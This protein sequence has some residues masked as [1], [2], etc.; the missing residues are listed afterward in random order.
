M[1]Q[2][3]GSN[4]RLLG[5][6]LGETIVHQDGH[7][8]FE[9]EEEVRAMAK[10]WRQGDSTASQRLEEIMPRI[11]GDL[12]L[13]D[14]TIKAF[15][16]YFQLVNL[17][18]ERQRVQVL[19]KR[20]E[21]AFSSGTS[22]DETII[23]GI[24]TLKL[25]GFSGEQVQSFL[26]SML[27]MLVFTAHP[28][29]SKRR[30]IRQI[31]SQVSQLLSDVGSR[32]LHLHERDGKVGL[33]R[34][35]IELLWQSS[36][37][38]ERRPTVM[39]EVRNTGLY[40]FENTLFELVPRIYEQI[41]HALKQNFPD[42]EFKVPTF[43]KYGTWIG[44]DRD[45][46]PFVT[47]AVTE[48]VLRAQKKQVLTLYL[49]DVD[50]LYQLLSCST[51]RT[52]FS[53]P[54][55]DSLD[56]DRT[57]ADE[58][59]FNVLDRFGQEPYRQKLVLMFRRLRAT[60]DANE[61]P[62]SD[63][64]NNPR[65]YR[66]A[67]EFRN[68]LVAIKESLL[69]NKGQFLARGRLERL[70]RAVDVFGFHLASMDIRQHAR[71][72]RTALAKVL[73][74]AGVAED[75]LA[76]EEPKRI[77]ALTDFMTN[78]QSDS[79]K[80]SIAKLLQLDSFDE[81]SAS[82]EDQET[83]KLV[84]LFE[85]IH[86]A[87]QQV[88][89]HT[90]DTYII[91]MTEGV[92]NM[93][94]I[95]VLARDAG[96]LGKLNIVPLFETVG[97]LLAAPAIMTE[98]FNHP[99]YAEH[100]ELRQRKQQIMI[101]YSDSNKD[102]GFMRANWMLFTAQRQMAKAC[103]DQNVMLTL[104]HGRGGSLGRGGG[105]TNRA[106]LAQPP[107]SVRGRIRITEQGEVVSS[108]YS[109]PA[110]ASRHLE[111]VLHAMIC[112]TGKRPEIE[113]TEKWSNIMDSLS[114]TAYQKYRSLVEHDDF[115]EYFQTATPIDQIDQLNIGSRPSHRRTTKSLDD[116]RAIP[117]VFAWTQSRANVPSWYGIGTAFSSW[118][119]D[120]QSATDEL[121]DKTQRL[122]LLQTMY[123]QWPFFRTM[124]SNVHLGMGRAD[125]EIA[126]MYAKLAK[127]AV[128]DVI[129]TDIKT[130]FELSREMLLQITKTWGILATEPWLQH[131]I[132][133]R[134][135]Y[136]D[137]LNYIQVALLKE[138]RKNPAHSDLKQLQNAIMLSINGIAAGLQN[139]G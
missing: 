121:T 107:E 9:L 40:F 10:A 112:S 56:Q 91:S 74:A 128:A 60:R 94:E 15:L 135:P 19:R 71:H 109:E 59:E 116:L 37:T 90:I 58:S 122:A 57:L 105:P 78:H 36:E 132:K 117:W 97:D 79:S 99:L 8:A 84:S 30:T 1:K 104:F 88:G 139:V 130:E 87:Q 62:W 33:L 101:G 63:Q 14:S 80:D 133:V 103:L 73:K 114:Q 86:E 69:A 134:N 125:M 68:D 64:T 75:Y 76:L 77:E 108:R 126:A 100:L 34:D 54:F 6:L 39:D 82:E 2:D 65:A 32:D 102:G 89:A 119:N 12:S 111:Q 83:A 72:H 51:N 81:A 106:I 3:I 4:I 21:T 85:L 118:L 18:E 46:N 66:S 113:N 52:S 48:D 49:Y 42:H 13:A 41:E 127:P 23:G 131:S 96:L 24:E 7:E 17:A 20:A 138:I 5:D 35:H 26:D 31:L 16:T 22:M 38:R 47:N 45:G 137:P 110:I 93:L 129:F 67:A 27:I 43:L 25:E 120:D 44:G 136:V 92:S 53:Q 115:L 70:I 124:L 29:E 123:Q 50:A 55:L 95:L 61:Q 11:V 98:L 28:T